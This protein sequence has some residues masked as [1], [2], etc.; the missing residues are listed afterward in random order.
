MRPIDVAGLSALAALQGASLLVTRVASPRCNSVPVADLRIIIG[1][2]LLLAFALPRGIT[3]DIQTRWHQYL[4]PGTINSAI[5]FALIASAATQLAA[6][7]SSILIATT[8]VFAALVGWVWLRDPLTSRQVAGVVL[9][10]A[11]V[12]LLVGWTPLGFSAG[13]MLSIGAVVGAA[14]C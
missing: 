5:P 9:G 11:G 3:F 7:I 13:V 6:S 1:G 12:V 4:V 10:L 14:L 8:P 2:L